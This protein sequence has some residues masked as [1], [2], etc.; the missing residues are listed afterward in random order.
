MR[1]RQWLVVGCSIVL[2][3]LVQVGLFADSFNP[4][5]NNIGKTGSPWKIAEKLGK[6]LPGKVEVT[7]GKD[8][9]PGVKISSVKRSMNIG[10]IEQTI[11][12]QPGLYEL[13][14]WAKG[15]GELVLRVDNKERYQKL[16]DEWGLYGFLFEAQ[17]KSS[18]V[19]IGV[20]SNFVNNPFAIISEAKLT[21]A[22]DKQ[23][24]VW[25]KR[26]DSFTQFGFYVYDAQRPTPGVAKKKERPI[27]DLKKMHD[28]V[29]C[30]D[31]RIDYSHTRDVPRL[32]KWLDANG[33]RIVKAEEL[34]TW[35]K[36]FLAED[37]DA[38]G[39]VACV[40]MGR[41]I[42]S[43][44]EEID[45]K[46]L[47]YH[48]LT[49]GGRIVNVGD[50]PF[51]NA[52]QEVDG[53]PVRGYNGGCRPLGMLF[54]WYSP[55]WGQGN[56]KVKLT[57]QGKKWGFETTD[58][59]ITGFAVNS[60][61]IPF[62]TFDVPGVPG[63][64]GASTWMK[65]LRPDMPWSGVIKICQNFYGNND[66]QMR[67]VWRA[68]NYVGQPVEIPKLPPPYVANPSQP[69]K[70]NAIAS[71]MPGRTE[72]KRGEKVKLEVT[73][74]KGL[75]I[76]GLTL[77]LLKDGKVLKT[78]K[79]D[80]KD[81]GSVAVFDIDT[82]PFTY[83][84]YQL[85]ASADAGGKKVS[86][87]MG[88]GIR[89][90]PPE[91]F[92]W[93][94]WVGDSTT[95]VRRDLI[96]KAIAEVGMEPC[97][98]SHAT[99]LMDAVLRQNNGFNLRMEKNATYPKTDDKSKFYRIDPDYQPHRDRAYGGGRPQ[100]GLTH[101]EVL[102][103]S[104]KGII[105]WYKPFAYHPALRP[106]IECNDDFSNW[107]GFDFAPHFRKKFEKMTG[108]KAPGPFKPK[109][110]IRKQI[111][112]PKQGIIEDNNPWVEW[113]RFTLEHGTGAFNMMQTEAVTSVRPD[114][115]IGPIPGGM[116]I[117]LVLMWGAGQYPPLNFG[118]KGFN[119]GYCYYYN[120]YWQPVMTNTYWLEVNR[121]GNRD[122]E[123]WLLGDVLF[124]DIYHRNNLFYLLAGGIKG[125]PY[126]TWDA[127]KLLPWKEIKHQA[128]VVKNIG[129]VQWQLQPAQRK[130]GL[131]L[132]FTADCF[133]PAD[134][135]IQPYAY[136][137]LLQA[138][139]DVDPICEEEILNGYCKKYPVIMLYYVRWLPK[140][141]VKA[142]Q[143]YIHGG[144]KLILDPTVPF[145]IPGAIRLKVDIG[146]GKEQT[147]GVPKGQAHLSRPGIND[148][149]CSKR[150]HTIAE[151]LGKYVKPLYECPDD[152]LTANTFRV[153]K[154]P[155]FWFVNAQTGEE[156]RVMRKNCGVGGNR[157]EGVKR[158][159]P[160]L[161]E[162]SRSTFSAPVTMKKMP[163]V[164]YDLLKGKRIQVKKT[165]D[166]EWKFWVDMER[167]GGTLVAFYPEPIT[168]VALDVP[169][170]VKPM[171]KVKIKVSVN[172]KSGL[173]PGA[174]PIEVKLVDP[175]GKESVISGNFATTDGTFTLDWVPAIND[176]K[177]KWTVKVKELASGLSEKKA[178]NL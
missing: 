84:T 77:E 120:S 66:R 96:Q 6:G 75:T 24:A 25:K 171:D 91:S 114:T 42:A 32:A 164:P 169:S 107:Y 57:E 103:A 72:F 160:W 5:L 149:G 163:G 14:V 159:R 48:Y 33:V 100:N 121:M 22:T 170:S 168:G 35:M 31:E 26:Q 99:R 142:L 62:S 161:D 65:N 87:E 79:S 106:K 162:I 8:R 92:S 95:Q 29:V 88:C 38:Y 157:E 47:W 113:C 18:R 61:S 130:I 89:H 111:K 59:S 58:G 122:I 150:I 67:D 90:V 165:D 56:L 36:Q 28:R 37:R 109:I 34:N 15:K 126:F 97:L 129:P 86:S 68:I 49:R 46:P 167:L 64:P 158:L 53:L 94:F 147:V 83:G 172:S 146:M 145:D 156:Y 9:K 74:K 71:G 152:T 119:L 93:G 39:T 41:P 40:C 78:W 17:K 136:A 173:V 10:A 104:R 117:P 144:G 30:W 81:K 44:V 2:L 110:D 21:K 70:M 123:V 27:R 132:P 112:I 80:I 154:V 52:P 85:K 12:L 11:D 7:K 148:Y 174:V 98:A 137:N 76:S 166:Q 118:K 19:I 138:H 69:L 124:D 4:E 1:R 51:Y 115:K 135:L 102:E 153:G 127:M 55:Y 143:E 45:G 176:S 116:Q 54:G 134:H 82:L 13:T 131:L 20:Q 23:K 50:L 108:L 133:S 105:E 3:F 60:V 63:V 125:L 155:Y 128:S 177:G 141:V 175:K 16:G 140:K 43:I 101:P 178:I 73:P 139:F 151:E